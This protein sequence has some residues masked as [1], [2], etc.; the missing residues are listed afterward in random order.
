MHDDLHMVHRS[1]TQWT[2]RMRISDNDAETSW[3][4]HEI[5]TLEALLR[6]LRQEMADAGGAC[7]PTR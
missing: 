7:D 5:M 4:N 1:S 2:L 6:Q 3:D